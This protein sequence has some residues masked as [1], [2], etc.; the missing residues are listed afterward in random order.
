MR[1]FSKADAASA[2]A[3]YKM[4]APRV[5][6]ATP[7]S[8]TETTVERQVSPVFLTQAFS[9]EDQTSLACGVILKALRVSSV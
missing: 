7:G 6:V 5:R 8:S 4:A 9:R 3:L 2:R 1:R